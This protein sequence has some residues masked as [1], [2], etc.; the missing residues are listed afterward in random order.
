MYDQ[1]DQPGASVPMMIDT[2][3]TEPTASPQVI[4]V[5]SHEGDAG[6]EAD[7]YDVINFLLKKVEDQQSRIVE[8]EGFAEL[9]NQEI[10][11][12]KA[13]FE[14]KRSELE[15][16]QADYDVVLQNGLA[17]ERELELLRAR[18]HDLE[19]ELDG[20]K[21]RATERPRIQLPFHTE[22]KLAK[23]GYGD[24]EEVMERQAV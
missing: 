18:A 16:T 1:F 24:V 12:I 14:A 13:Q 8:H 22:Q 5:G 15:A 7:P 11:Q 19:L 6:H 4:W 2:P 10:D 23:L 20:F 21:T 9:Q 17:V 3:E